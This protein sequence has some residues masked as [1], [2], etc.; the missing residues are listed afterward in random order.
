MVEAAN[1]IGALHGYTRRLLARVE[2]DL[3]RRLE[4]I[5]VDHW[6]TDNPHTHLVIRG[7]DESGGDLVIAREYIT[8]GMRVRATELATE[9]LGPRSEAEIQASLTREISQ[10]SLLRSMRCGAPTWWT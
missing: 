5:A 7:R 3:G 10:D 6:D 9:W 8:H 4:W 1:E 2:Q